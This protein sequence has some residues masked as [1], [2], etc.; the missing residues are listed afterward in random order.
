M[1]RSLKKLLIENIDRSTVKEFQQIINNDGFLG[2]K[3]IV[4]SEKD[5]I[6]SDNYVLFASMDSLQHIADRHL[7]RNMP[8]SVFY[9]GTDLQKVIQE[10]MF[11]NP[12][13]DINQFPKVKWIDI[14]TKDPVGET[15]LSVADPMEVQGMQDFATPGGRGEIVKV[16]PGNLR[17]TRKVSLITIKLG[18]LEDGREALSLI[19]LF[20]GDNIIDGVVV[21]ADRSRFAELGLYFQLPPESPAFK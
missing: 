14:R 3:G 21:P 4:V 8:G 20:P 12:P 18:D 9:P 13:N 2:T 6:G 7:D 1:K 19:T 17:P 11:Y 5:L 15:G 16:S 10:I